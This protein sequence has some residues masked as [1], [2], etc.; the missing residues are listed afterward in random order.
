MFGSRV[1]GLWVEAMF[2]VCTVRSIHEDIIS[3]FRCAVLWSFFREANLSV[4]KGIFD[5]YLPGTRA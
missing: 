4:S 2:F 1:L 5:V 3:F